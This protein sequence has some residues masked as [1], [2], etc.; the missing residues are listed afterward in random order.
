MKQKEI[1]EKFISTCPEYNLYFFINECRAFIS[2]MSHD[3]REGK[4]D[5]D[6]EKKMLIAEDIK[7]VRETQEKAVEQ[8]KRFGVDF[9]IVEEYD[10]TLKKN[11]KK[12]CSEYKKWY[13]HWDNWKKSLSDEN[14][15]I[16]VTKIK[17]EESIEEFLPNKKWNH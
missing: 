7:N 15:D 16:I 5:L 4:I 2:A 11:V 6:E 14:W 17:K 12:A 10:N 9:K 3:L 1:L 8:T 13:R